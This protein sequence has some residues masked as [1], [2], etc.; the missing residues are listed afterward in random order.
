MFPVS[1]LKYMLFSHPDNVNPMDFKKKY[2]YL[3]AKKFNKR[4]FVTFNRRV[5]SII[6]ALKKTL[7]KYLN[8][9]SLK[10]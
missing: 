2:K 9:L 10:T 1:R 6:Y 7:S 3:T 5:C 4:F 8:V